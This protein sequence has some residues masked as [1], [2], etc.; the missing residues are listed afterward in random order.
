MQVQCQ[1]HKAH[2]CSLS[3]LA[4]NVFGSNSG[5]MWE[6]T[7]ITSLSFWGSLA[8]YRPWGVLWLICFKRCFLKSLHTDQLICY[9]TCLALFPLY[10]LSVSSVLALSPS[11]QTYLILAYLRQKNEH[12]CSYVLPSGLLGK[13]AKVNLARYHHTSLR[14]QDSGS[15]GRRITIS[16]PTLATWDLASKQQ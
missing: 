1:V 5:D 9:I 3:F 7:S 6:T 8:L 2:L 12:M 14:Y 16:R 11:L 13:M 15:W 4:K 10:M